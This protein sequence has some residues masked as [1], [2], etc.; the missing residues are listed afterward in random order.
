MNFYFPCYSKILQNTILGFF[1]DV[2]STKRSVL[3]YYIDSSFFQ[4]KKAYKIEMCLYKDNVLTQ[5]AET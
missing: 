1:S 2:Y 5:N 3:Y 4:N